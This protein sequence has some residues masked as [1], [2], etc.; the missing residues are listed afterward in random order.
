MS[1]LTFSGSRPTGQEMREMTKNVLMKVKFDDAGVFPNFKEYML[2]Q[3][4]ADDGS[5]MGDVIT[6]SGLAITALDALTWD[7]IDYVDLIIRLPQSGAA[8]NV[9]SNNSVEAF[10]RVTDAV[11]GKKGHF[12]VPAW[13]DAVYDK[14]PNGA[15]SAAYNIAAAAFNVFIR[16]PETGNL[17]DYVAAQNRATKR[18]QRQFRP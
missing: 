14:A 11:T 9:A 3:T 2:V 7:H 5:D 10:H 12:I 18:G 16:N 8:A 1:G 6:Q 15:L 4:M 17:W 13:D